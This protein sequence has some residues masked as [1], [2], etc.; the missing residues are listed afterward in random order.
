MQSDIFM[1]VGQ[2]AKKMDVSVRTLQ[3]Y[4]RIG[5]LK[6][7]AASEGRRRLYSQKDMVTLHQILSLKYLGFSLDE[8]KSMLVSLDTPAQVA[9]VLAQQREMVAQ[10]IESLQAALGA[11]EALRQEVLQIETVDFGKYADIIV[12][13]KM[14]NRHY[15]VMKL[16]DDTLQRHVRERFMERPQLGEQILA[17]YENILNEAFALKNA[18]EPP[19]S[20]RSIA[21][22]GRWW[23][24]ILDFTGGD[25]SL[26]P[27]LM[28]LNEN[29][30][31]WDENMA[32]KQ[33]AI[34][35]FIGPALEAYMIQNGA[36]E[37]LGGFD[38]K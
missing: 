18:N 15:W 37:L 36:G 11:I 6:P 34:D 22:A 8:I 27:N 30:D 4:D 20:P 1:T 25:M 12:L 35:D 10:Q 16:M 5:L 7:S 26:I 24:M 28:K 38:G 13:L 19:D 21:L 29:K 31:G 9:D 3:Y 2:M 32:V 14:D 33:Q 17:T 23:Q